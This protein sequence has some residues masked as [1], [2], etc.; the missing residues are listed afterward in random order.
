MLRYF[1]LFLPLLLGWSVAPANADDSSHASA[2]ALPEYRITLKNQR[3][4][5]DKLEIP[6]DTKVKLLVTNQ[7]DY[8]AEFE[9]NDLDRER[10][11]APGRTLPIFIG[12]LS[13]GEYE[14]EEEFHDEEAE[15]VIIVK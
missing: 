8:T 3:F 15:G 1:S 13:P 4:S 6:A 2:A 7:D 9:S 5:P 10:T 12:P 14:F 11:I